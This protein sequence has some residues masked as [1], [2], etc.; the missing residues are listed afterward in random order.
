[1]PYPIPVVPNEQATDPIEAPNEVASVTGLNAG[2]N[3][4]VAAHVAFPENWDGWWAATSQSDF[5]LFTIW[6]NSTNYLSIGMK[7]NTGGANLLQ[8]IVGNVVRNWTLVGPIPL[9][10]AF[11]ALSGS[12]IWIAASKRPDGIRLSAR[13][14]GGDILTGSQPFNLLANPQEVRIGGPTQAYVTPL[15]VFAVLCDPAVGLDSVELES[16]LSGS[17]LITG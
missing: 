3:W 15:L 12:P 14:G 4:T 9:A 11:Y 2:S 13:T 6:G 16:L 1:M 8:S 17:S 7:R 10:N 5:P